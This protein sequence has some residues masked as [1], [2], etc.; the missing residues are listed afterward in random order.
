MEALRGRQTK[1]EEEF[2]ILDV[3]VFQS[4]FIHYKN[5]SF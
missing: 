3:R 1:E 2:E 5:P 4:K